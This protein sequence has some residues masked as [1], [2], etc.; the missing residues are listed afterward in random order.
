MSKKRVE[1]PV[2]EKSVER[3]MK[4]ERYFT[5][6][7]PSM[8]KYTKAA[9]VVDFHGIMK[10]MKEWETALKQYIGA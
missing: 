3:T 2:E 5:I 7:K 1:M 8:H 6:A 10:T 4:I 9:V